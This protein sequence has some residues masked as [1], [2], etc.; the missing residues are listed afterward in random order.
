MQ[1]NQQGFAGLLTRHWLTLKQGHPAAI[2]QG[3]EALLQ[4]GLHSRS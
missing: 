3:Q 2:G 1:R 4:H